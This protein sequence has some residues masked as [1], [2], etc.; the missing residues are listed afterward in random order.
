M[1]LE[2]GK[3]YKWKHEPQVLIYVGKNNGWHQ[4]ALVNTDELWCECLDSDLKLMEIV[5]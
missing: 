2:V 3:K 1:K 5:K 4:F